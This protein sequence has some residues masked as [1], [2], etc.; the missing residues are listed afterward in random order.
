MEIAEHLPAHVEQEINYLFCF[1]Y[2]NGSCFPRYTV[3]ISTHEF[4]SFYAFNSLSNPAGGGV[5]ECLHGT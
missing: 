1:A 4:S 2:I 5:S 3:Y